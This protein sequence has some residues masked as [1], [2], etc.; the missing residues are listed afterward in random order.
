[1]IA[2]LPI[3]SDH[4]LA[5]QQKL[6]NQKDIISESL[7]REE[8]LKLEK[9]RLEIEQSIAEYL[10]QISES[11]NIP[12]DIPILSDES[13]SDLRK[14]QEDSELLLPADSIEL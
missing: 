5:A 6:D 13:D 1:M 2:L 3:I 7:Y 8:S 4:Y 14:N 12:E 11:L 9:E 10:H